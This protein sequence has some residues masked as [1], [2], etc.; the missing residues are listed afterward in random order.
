MPNPLRDIAEGRPM[1]TIRL[2]TW[3][4]D[5]SGNRSKSY[6]AHT[7]TYIANVSLPHKQLLQE[8]FVRFS[9]TSQHASCPEQF[10]AIYRD[11]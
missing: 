3:G 10:T 1:F 2:A 11:L 6:N 4:D 5:V 8:Y 7:N 9:S